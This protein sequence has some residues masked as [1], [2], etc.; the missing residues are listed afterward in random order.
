VIKQTYKSIPYCFL[1][2][3]NDTFKLMCVWWSG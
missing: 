3:L 2:F 1:K